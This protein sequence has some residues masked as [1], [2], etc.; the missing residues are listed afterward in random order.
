MQ[1]HDPGL[2][3]QVAAV[4]FVL[5][6]VVEKLM[7]NPDRKFI[8]VEQA[9]FQRWWREQGRRKRKVV[10]KLV[11]QGRLEFINGGW[12]MHDEATT[13]YV[14]MIDQTALGHRYIRRQFGQ[15]PRVAWQIDPFGHSAVQAYLL[16]AEAGFDGVFFA[17]GDYQDAQKR[18]DTKSMEFV[19]RASPSLGKSAQVALSHRAS[20]PPFS[21]GN[22]RAAGE[23]RPCWQASRQLEV[24]VGRSSSQQGGPTT[25]LLEEAVA[26]VQ[27]HDGTA[28]TE[29][30]HVASDYSKRLALGYAQASEVMCAA[31]V[32]LTAGG[33]EQRQVERQQQPQQQEAKEEK[34]LGRLLIE[35][36]EVSR[37]P[38]TAGALLNPREGE[39]GE[40]EGEE[41]EAQAGEAR[42][43]D[44]GE[45]EEEG[46][47]TQGAA[48]GGSWTQAEQEEGEGP[49]FEQCALL[50]ISH[51]PASQAALAGTANTLV[52]VAYNPLAWS[53][54][55]FVRLPVSSQAL[56][57]T[58]SSGQAV[59]SQVVPLPHVTA[60]VRAFYAQAHLGQVA[61]EAE[62]Q[63]L[64][65]FEA[66][67]APLGFATYFVSAADKSS[68]N[69]DAAALSSDEMPLSSMSF[70][71]SD[72]P[73]VNIGVGAKKLHFSPLT[74]HLAQFSNAAT[75][76]DITVDQ[77]YL[78][79][80]ASDGEIAGREASGAYVFR[81]N[82]SEALAMWHD[83]DANMIR[84]SLR[85]VRGP[86]V[87]ECHQSFSPWSS[88]V[89][90]MY[91]DAEHAEVEFTV[92]P[93]P[94]EDGLG[95][96]VITRL[97]TPLVSSKTFY[98]DSNGRDYIKRVVDYRDDW[99]LNVT[100][101]VAGNYY[102]INAGIYVSDGSTDFSVL[103]DRSVG[104][105]SLI[106]GQI[107][108]MLH[109]HARTPARSCSLSCSHALTGMPSL[110]RLLARSLVFQN[111]RASVLVLEARNFLMTRLL[112]DDHKGV[113]EALN[114]T[115]CVG[116]PPV[117]Q[118][119]TVT[120]KYYV[121]IAGPA[122][123]ARWRRTHAQRLLA[124]LQLAFTT[125]EGQ[126]PEKWLGT[127]RGAFSATAGYELP[128]NVALITL[129]E[130]DDGTVLFRLAHLY[131]AG[132]DDEYSQLAVVDLEALFAGKKEGQG[133][134]KWLGTRRGAFSATAGYELPPNVA[135]ITLQLE[136]VEEMSL[137][138]NQK[139][140]DMRAPLQWTIDGA[141]AE[142]AELAPE[143]R[144]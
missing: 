31:L 69:G 46:A 76:E 136:D 71:D 54:S 83:S 78:W 116:T 106:D 141:S 52:V 117:C 93:I 138:A 94:V 56:K 125:I 133:P 25:D 2:T 15:R 121:N 35:R 3:C 135:L 126:G 79:Y 131:E 65:V 112:H 124:P 29:K 9:F 129:Q 113:D 120:G 92:G 72:E 85:V 127:R 18:R 114:E 8:Y 82:S 17:R 7:E 86:L 91:K 62:A 26:I 73:D 134:E 123:S 58:D 30:Q 55:E 96:E 43:V 102:P 53:R 33:Q 49:R 36:E 34:P 60:Q 44:E 59:L 137:T 10:K 68:E 51:C 50:N 109:R 38:L 39:A 108:L 22:C 37:S 81:P 21:P 19:W 27:H 12:C 70:P 118:G 13:H 67:V 4:Q 88:H 142:E 66:Q 144:Q 32:K 63:L 101:P 132:E 139:K 5:D 45:K 104:G 95:K 64:L 28:G 47:G 98:T 6:S 100:D 103:V 97:M 14:D 1:T 77:T 87:H 107:E 11:A 119:L 24:L 16:G 40:E 84:P 90:R 57:V 110:L 61:P 42:A 74:G 128:P 99:S 111:T 80:N 41:G 20:S 122:E 143:Q 89:V 23:L 48:K 140:R 105:S 75:G 115:V 130:L